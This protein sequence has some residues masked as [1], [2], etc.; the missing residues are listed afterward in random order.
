M[1]TLHAQLYLLFAI[2]LTGRSH[3][4]ILLELRKLRLGG[5]AEKLLVQVTPRVNGKVRIWFH[6]SLTLKLTLNPLNHPYCTIKVS[7]QM[8]V[9]KG[10]IQSGNN[11]V[12][13]STFYR[14]ERWALV[15]VLMRGAAEYT[16]EVTMSLLWE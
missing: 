11:R 13:F 7:V 4:Y 9:E 15:L 1:G 14:R 3:A 6:G 2:S 12:S 5:F 10:R 8:V 16:E